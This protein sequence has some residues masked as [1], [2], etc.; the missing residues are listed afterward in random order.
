MGIHRGSL[1]CPNTAS[2][3][4]LKR[5]GARTSLG[6]HCPYPLFP[7]NTYDA[8]SYPPKLRRFQLVRFLL[9]LHVISMV[10]CLFQGYISRARCH[11]LLGKMP[12]EQA[13]YAHH[14][15]TLLLSQRVA[16][17]VAQV[18]SFLLCFQATDLVRDASAAF[19]PLTSYTGLDD[20]RSCLA[21]ESMPPLENPAPQFQEPTLLRTC[22]ED[23]CDCCGT[24]ACS[25]VKSGTCCES[26]YSTAGAGLPL[27]RHA[28]DRPVLTA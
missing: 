25:C 26:V 22:S 6:T 19:V 14:T 23:C 16:W 11:H 3:A 27:A 7:S 18:G 24:P 21:V 9:C 20:S 2:Q 17:R 15:L 4:C 8:M 12:I 28:I 1:L 5:A 13:G 10:K